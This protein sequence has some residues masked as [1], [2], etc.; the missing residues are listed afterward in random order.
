MHLLRGVRRAGAGER[1]SEL[2]RRFC[3]A[4][5][6]PGQR[7][8]RHR[9]R[10]RQPPG[11]DHPPGLY[12]EG[13]STLALNLLA[14]DT[15]LQPFP[16]LPG[17]A[18]ERPYGARSRFDVK[19]WLIGLALALLFVDAIASLRLR[20]YRLGL[21]RP[22]AAAAALLLAMG[23]SAAPPPARAQ[24]GADPDAF[25]LAASLQTRLAYVATGDGELDRMSR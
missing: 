21:R 15:I 2:R 4:S 10:P 13:P 16:D 18:A 7:S 25:A 9:A 8:A 12:G 14:P 3:P 23:I 20:G 19:P 22:A 17:G 6:P 5:D 11:L 1:L 24:D